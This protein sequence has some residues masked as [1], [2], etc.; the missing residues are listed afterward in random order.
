LLI[1][2]SV[3]QRYRLPRAAMF[4][5]TTN[6]SVCSRTPQPFTALQRLPTRMVILTHP[7]VTTSLGV[8]RAVI[9]SSEVIGPQER[10]MFRGRGAEVAA[11]FDIA[12]PPHTPSPVRDARCNTLHAAS[13]PAT[14][15]AQPAVRPGAH[16]E[17]PVLREG[18]R[19]SGQTGINSSAFR[20]TLLAR[21]IRSCVVIASVEDRPGAHPTH[22]T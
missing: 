21:A 22:L 9:A 6:S 8:A 20:E 12:Q 19:A 7:A 17:A 5:D 3:G 14:A 15:S 13:G 16:R 18:S 4:S 10:G 2:P 1:A 11:V